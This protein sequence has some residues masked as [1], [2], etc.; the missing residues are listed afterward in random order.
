MTQEETMSTSQEIRRYPTNSECI[1]VNLT[2][3]FTFP[4]HWHSFYEFELVVSG[5]GTQVINGIE[6]PYSF[7]NAFLL[8]PA[9]FHKRTV[10]E[11]AQIWIVKIP[12][13]LMPIIFADGFSQGHLPAVAHL[14][15]QEIST[16][17]ELL[18]LLKKHS[19]NFDSFDISLTDSILKTLFLYIFSFKK[20]TREF[21]NK[22]RVSIIYNYLQEHFSEAISL[23]D[24]A[25]KFNLSDK[26]LCSYFKKHTGRTIINTLR[27]MR[28]FHASH[29][30]IA[31]NETIQQIGL[32][33]GYNS[34]S[35]FLRDFRKKFGMTPTD[36][37]K[38]RGISI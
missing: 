29:M 26:Y 10:T 9:D 22:D 30:T 18:K 31:S 14:N 13:W 25:Q 36:M 23:E 15:N 5:E 7:G 1:S 34:L 2:S 19:D 24:L 12:I 32:K 33:C 11:S 35:F 3:A 37:R 38:K 6:Y 16:C 8:G 28:M 4:I 21:G 20:R 27:E 17:I